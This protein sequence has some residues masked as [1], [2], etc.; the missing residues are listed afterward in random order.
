MVPKSTIH[1]EVNASDELELS[2]LSIGQ[3]I[4]RVADLRWLLSE[5]RAQADRER[6]LV[7][8]H[9]N[10]AKREREAV[11]QINRQLLTQI[12]VLLKAQQVTEL[13][14]REANWTRPSK[15]INISQLQQLTF[16][17]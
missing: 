1:H 7:A 6:E 3:L 8:I 14:I 5:Q 4:Q 13:S 10:T 2:T 9:R 16:S 15:S 11:M 17:S 12:K